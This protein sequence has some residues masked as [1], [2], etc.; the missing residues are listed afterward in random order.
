M[1]QQNGAVKPYFRTIVVIPVG[2]NE[3]I[4]SASDT[5]SSIERY[6]SS[7]HKVIIVDNSRKDSGAALKL[8]YPEIDIVKGRYSGKF[9]CLFLNISLGTAHAFENYAFDVLLRMDADALITGPNPDLD[10]VAYF[11]QNPAVGQIGVY[12]FDYNGKRIRWFPVNVSM[13]AQALNPMSWC[14]PSWNGWRF[15]EILLNAFANGYVAGQH[16]FGGGFFLSYA[17]VARLY[18]AG[19]LSDPRLEKLRLQEDHITSVGVLSVG[20]T[21]GDFAGGD[22]PFAQAWR[23]LPASP[24]ELIRRKKKSCTR[25]TA[26]VA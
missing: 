1:Y 9:A 5:L 12:R 11:T 10:A 4:E 7:S 14:L 3:K 23:G 13:L 18:R 19:I 20:F 21:L 15:R 8:R 17:C 6:L 16:I 26:G 22:Y 24:E 25:C 2:P